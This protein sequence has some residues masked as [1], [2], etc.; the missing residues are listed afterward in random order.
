MAKTL[1]R[2][3]DIDSFMEAIQMKERVSACLSAFITQVDNAGLG[4][5]RNNNQVDADS[6]YKQQTLAPGM[7]MKLKP[8]EGVQVVN[9]TNGAA[10]AEAYIQKHSNE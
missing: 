7:I 4:G 3:K 10:N 8:G 9:P 5:G 6:G 2:I 1:K